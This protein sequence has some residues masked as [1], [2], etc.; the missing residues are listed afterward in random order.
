MTLGILKTID[1][2]A[3]KCWLATK[4][5]KQEP[6]NYNNYNQKKINFRHLKKTRSGR[7]SNLL[8]HVSK[9]TALPPNQVQC[10]WK[11]IRFDNKTTSISIT[12]VQ[13]KLL[14]EK[15]LNPNYKRL[16]HASVIITKYVKEIR[17]NF[18]L[19]KN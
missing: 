5:T 3:K 7:D 6:T 12:N 15:R 17:K 9:A 4:P 14:T 11:L 1:Y 18:Q 13:E 8:Y 2:S 10:A 19:Q 16:A